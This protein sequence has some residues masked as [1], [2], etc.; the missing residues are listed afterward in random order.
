[1]PTTAPLCAITRL[2]KPF[3]KGD[4]INALTSSDPEDTPK[5]VT[6]AGSPP[7]AAMFLCTHRSAAIWSS[8]P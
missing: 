3:D 4:V 8:M 6:F 1:M 5:I 7:N 2:N